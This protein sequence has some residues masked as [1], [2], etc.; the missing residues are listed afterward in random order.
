MIE[1]KKLRTSVKKEED[2]LDLLL[3][4]GDSQQ[5]LKALLHKLYQEQSLQLPELIGI[6]Q[7]AKQEPSIPLSIFNQVLDPAEALYKF[8]K[9]NEGFSFQQIG[10]ETG[11]EDKSIWATY[12][13]SKKKKQLFQIHD[14]KYFL[15]LTIFKS[16]RY[17]FLE[18]IIFYLNNTYHLSNKEIAKL[19]RRTPNTIA[20]LIK[21]ARDKHESA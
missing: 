10:Q 12:Q 13:R 16:R 18:S 19:L 7:L 14:E 1:S 20:V 15:P 21:R 5:L 6:F 8:L 2:A 11:R 4:L 9:E 3:S 17:S